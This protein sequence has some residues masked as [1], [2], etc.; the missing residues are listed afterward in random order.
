MYLAY[1]VLKWP[2]W[3]GQWAL[4]QVYHL[5]AHRNHVSVFPRA[6]FHIGT[7]VDVEAENVELN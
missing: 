7:L 2:L 1:N 5:T 6:H 3:A 4:G